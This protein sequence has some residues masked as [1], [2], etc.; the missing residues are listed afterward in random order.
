MLHNNNDVEHDL[1]KFDIIKMGF[2]KYYL[3]DA[4][5]LWP[6]FNYSKFYTISYFIKC[7]CKYKSVV[8]YNIAHNEAVHKYLFKVF[9]R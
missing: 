2:K 1:Y 5:P 7:I 3:I 6:K 9:Y 4:K 8:N